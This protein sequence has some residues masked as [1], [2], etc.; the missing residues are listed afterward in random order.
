ML[1]ET[2]SSF[3]V[4]PARP[5]AWHRRATRASGQ[6]GIEVPAV[7]PAEAGIQCRGVTKFLDAGLPR[8]CGASRHDG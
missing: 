1:F 8:I 2:W 7:I 5:P 3:G 6:A 4:I